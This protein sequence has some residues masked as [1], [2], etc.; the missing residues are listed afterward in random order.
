MKELLLNAGTI[1]LDEDFIAK[2]NEQ[3]ARFKKEV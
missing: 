2:T 3:L 1:F